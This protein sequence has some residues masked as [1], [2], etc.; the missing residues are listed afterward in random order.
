[1]VLTRKQKAFVAAVREGMG[2]EEAAAKA[3]YGVEYA[4]RLLEEPAIRAA[5]DAPDREE[6]ERAQTPAE[7]LRGIAMDPTQD[8][9]VRITA[10]RALYMQERDVKTPPPPPVIIDD[11]PDCNE[12]EFAEDCR[13][14]H[15]KCRKN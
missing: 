5:S 13:K 4:A 1:M 7:M 15:L 11:I 8:E 2:L 9:R 14:S 10:A 3:G 12:C 6:P